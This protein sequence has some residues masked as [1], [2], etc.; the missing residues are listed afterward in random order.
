MGQPSPTSPNIFNYAVNRGKVYFK[1]AG[2]ADYVFVG[3]C[4]QA[5]VQVK[6]TLLDHYSSSEGVQT[7]DLTVPTRLEGT[8]TCSLEE[9]TAR[10][11]GY[12]LLGI[13]A[14]SPSG[15][16]SIDMM[17]NPLFQV[18]FKFVATNVVGPQWTYECELVTLT[19]TKALD[20][21]A[22]GSGDWGT[23]DL[24]ADVLKGPTT[25][26]FCVATSSSFGV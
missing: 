17:S 10:N 18:G 24:Q 11:I 19:P 2:D 8:I 5:T 14:D 1:Q 9:M 13:P 15:E 25:G 7:K 4:K 26:Q 20:L 3:N 22:Q 21:I 16:V 12:A 23:V 6:P